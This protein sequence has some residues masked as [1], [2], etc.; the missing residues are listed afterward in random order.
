[1][2]CTFLLLLLAAAAPG[3]YGQWTPRGEVGAVADDNP[4][5]AAEADDVVPVRGGY[6]AL[7]LGRTVVLGD[8]W[9]AHL[10][11]DLRGE[12]FT[13]APGLDLLSFRAEAAL[14]WK[15]GYG[16]LAPWVEAGLG[17]SRDQFR[18]TLRNAWQGKVALRAGKRLTTSLDLQAEGWAERRRART[19]PPEAP[20]VSADAFSQAST[21]LRVAAE[22]ALPANCYLTLAVLRRQGD[23]TLASTGGLD[24]YTQARAA[25]ADPTFGPGFFAYRYPGATLGARAALLWAISERVALVL[26]YERMDTD[27]T[28]LEAYRRGLATLSTRFSF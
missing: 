14:R 3:L 1:M 12:G 6:A 19:G 22:L 21:G 18:Q 16:A 5:N 10:A 9:R 13:R 15:L 8:A 24:E 2:R 25:V 20:G 7:G 27:V 11:G 28:G 23:V 26:A 17:A 4:G